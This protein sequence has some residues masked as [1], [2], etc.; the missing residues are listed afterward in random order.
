MVHQKNLYAKL[1][2]KQ[3]QFRLIRV[4]N[5]G[6]DEISCELETHP[7]P[8]APTYRAL[9]YCWTDHL[10]TC[11]ITLDEH[12]F[13]VRPNLHDY[14][15]Q[16]RAECD[17]S[18][19]FIDAL[20][21]NQDDEREKSSQLR[22]MG[23]IYRDASEVVAWLGVEGPDRMNMDRAMPRL[24]EL[25]GESEEEN[26][27]LLIS[28]QSKRKEAYLLVYA[29]FNLRYWSR[30]WIF[31]EVVLARVLVLQFRMI[32][33][34]AK[35][36]RLLSSCLR[37]SGPLR[38]EWDPVTCAS[39]LY[40]LPNPKHQHQTPFRSK[41]FDSLQE[42]HENVYSAMFISEH[43]FVIREKL[44]VSP[45]GNS[46]IS[47]KVA[48][49]RTMTQTCLRPYDR[50]YGL[51]GITNSR[52]GGDYRMRKIN[53]YLRALLEG[54]LERGATTTRQLE[55]REESREDS[56]EYPGTLQ[57]YVTLM[58]RLELSWYD[59]VVVLATTRALELLGR[60]DFNLPSYTNIVEKLMMHL[61]APKART[62][63]Q[64]SKEWIRFQAIRSQ[65][66]YYR[67]SDLPFAGPDGDE[68]SKTYEQWIE[69]F[70]AIFNNVEL[71]TRWNP[72]PVKPLVF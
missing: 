15:K 19:I 61:Q 48:V 11:R 72:N 27:D 63:F 13:Y 65:L 36:A 14:L 9:S 5:N 35:V 43:F 23:D 34:S 44:Q 66:Q 20:C 54:T 42:Y 29:M 50:I 7:Q 25:I 40:L 22:L 31:Q 8:N 68:V 1:D 12:G 6:G 45:T 57:F 38:G 4:L 69:W 10:P 16:V 26:V 18:L 53:L 71:R 55:R 41:E 39:R 37:N 59:P 58:L 46:A 28:D 30:L 21:I 64:S 24:Q 33:L 67:I 32:R 49:D 17:S 51:L 2:D 56:R 70:D 52:L 3:R 60:Y 62:Y 47:I